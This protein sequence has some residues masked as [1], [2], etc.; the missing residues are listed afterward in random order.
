MDRQASSKRRSNIDQP[1]IIGGGH[2]GL[3]LALALESHGLCPTLVDLAPVDIVLKTPFDG[4]ALALMQGSKQVF[5]TLGLW[6]AMVTAA[7]P[8]LSVQVHDVGIDGTVTYDAK[9]FGGDPLGYGI[10]NRM[11]R[12]RLLEFVLARPKIRVIAPASLEHLERHRHGL[13]ACLSDGS[14]IDTPLV[15]GADGRRSTVRRLAGIA[16]QRRDYRQTAITLAFRH[17]RPHGHRVR[18]YMSKAGPLALLPIGDDLSSA[19]WVE[20]PRDAQKLL[21]GDPDDLMHGLRT[22]QNDD[23]DPVEIIGSPGSHYLSAETAA[24]YVAPRVALVGDAA[25]GLHPIHA[26]GWNL[27]VRDVAALAEVLVDAYRCNQDPG[28][29]ESLQRYARCR[30]GDASLTFGL[31]DGLNRLFA[32]DLMPAK[33][34][35]RTGLTMLNHIAPM[36]TW[37]MRRG[38]GVAGNQPKLVRGQPLRS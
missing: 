25:H 3:L 27:G 20:R 31:T 9:A 15:I 1:L 23:L 7:T 12:L 28:S 17:L 14:V 22:R 35:R 13:T 2:S 36:K 10:E 19:T 11:L 6:P 37:A 4:R 21:S 29:G 8:I 32:S 30:S 5:D 38:M 18:E 16:V 24:R 33:L 26:Q 34:L